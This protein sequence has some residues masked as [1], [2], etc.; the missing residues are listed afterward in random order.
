MTSISEISDR[1]RNRSLGIFNY[2]AELSRLR[3][4]TICDIDLYQDVFWFDSLPK[5]KDCHTLAWGTDDG[6]EQTDQT[7]LEIKKRPE[8][9]CP[10]P[11]AICR[12]WID[13]HTLFDSDKLPQLRERIPAPRPPASES[14]NIAAEFSHEPEYLKLSDHPD[15]RSEFESYVQ[16]RWN[17]WSETH[18]AWKEL[19]EAY[20]ALFKIHQELQR[21]GEQYE[22]I[23]GLGFLSWHTPSG[24]PVGRHVLTAQATL[25]FD[26]ANGRF[27]LRAGAEGAK[28]RLESDMLQPAD[29]PTVEQQRS[30]E[31]ALGEAAETPWDRALVFPIL[32]AWVQSLEDRGEFNDSLIR[33][34]GAKESP[35]IHFSPAII[36]RRRTGQ[37]LLAA[38]EK[39]IECIKAPGQDIPPE[40]LRLVSDAD[41]FEQWVESNGPPGTDRPSDGPESVYFPLPANEEQIRIVE[42][43]ERRQGVLVQGPP[44][45]GKSHTIANLICHLLATGKRVLV[46]AQTP[47]ALRVLQDKL[48]GE[49]TPLCVSLLGNDRS[50]LENLERSVAEISNRYARWNATKHESETN[51]LQKELTEAKSFLAILDDKARALRERETRVHDVCGDVYRGTAQRIAAKISDYAH[52][53]DWFRDRIP[54]NQEIPIG[55][56]AFQQLRKSLLDIDA[57]RLAELKQQRPVLAT[58]PTLEDFVRLVRK[59]HV[60]MEAV[61]GFAVARTRPNFEALAG[62]S[63]EALDQLACAIH[64][65]R[66]AV[67]NIERRPLKWIKDAIFGMLTDQDRPWKSLREATSNGLADLKLRANQVDQQTLVMPDKVDRDQVLADAS[68]LKRHLDT[69]KGYGWWIFVSATVKRTRYVSQQVRIDGRTCSDSA[70]LRLLIEALQ[71]RK[72]VDRLWITWKG[73]AD[74]PGGLLALQIAEL[75]E[76]LE[77]LD[78]V[79]AI[80]NALEPAKAACHVVHGLGEPPWHDCQALD[81]LLYLHNAL[82]AERTLQDVREQMSGQLEALAQVSALPNCHPV[83]SEISAAIEARDTEK[84]ARCL[85]KLGQIDKDREKVEKRS[86]WLAGLKRFAPALTDDLVHSAEDGDWERRLERIADAWNWSRA[87]SWLEEYLR[88][89]REEDLAKQIAETRDSINGL[90]AQL[91]ARRAWGHFFG[92][93]TERQRQHLNAWQQAIQ[94]LGKG[95]GRHAGRHRRQA[96]ESLSHCQGAIPAWVMPMYRVF[97]TI[98][99]EP[100][101]FDVLIVDEASQC[102]PDAL[103]LLYLAKK[104][105]VVGDDQQ[106]SPEAV[107]INQDDVDYLIRQH[108]SQ[109]EHPG[110]FGITSSFFGHG[111]IRYGNR[112]VLRE[113]FRCMPE[114]IRFSNDLCY[115]SNPLIPLRQYPPHRLKPVVTRRVAGGFREGSSSRVFNRPEA[116]AV[117][118][119]IVACCNDPQ[120]ENKTMGVI[121]LQGDAQ[122]R[123]IE[124]MLLEHLDAT[125]IEERRIIC[126]DAY[127]FQGDERN[128]IFLS[129]VAAPNTRIGTLTKD[130]DKRRFNVAASR[131]QDQ[132]WLFHSAA[133]EDLNSSCLRYELLRYCLNPLTQRITLEGLDVEALQKLARTA[134]RHKQKA[135][136]PFDSWFEVDLF[137]M[138]IARGYRVIPQYQVAGYRIDLVV[139]GT[140]ARLAVE[141]DGDE[142]HGAETYQQDVERQRALERC[143]WKF[144]RVRGSEFYRNPNAAT[145]SLWEEIEARGIEIAT[146]QFEVTDIGG[147]VPRIDWDT[148]P[149]G[150]EIID[151]AGV[152]SKQ[153]TTSHDASLPRAVPTDNTPIPEH[154]PKPVVEPIGETTL[155]ERERGIEPGAVDAGVAKQTHGV[156]MPGEPTGPVEANADGVVNDAMS[157]DQGMWFAL[158][159]WAKEKDTL[160][161]RD[162]AMLYNMARKR[163]REEPLT[164]KQAR[165]A[166]DLY[167]QLVEQGFHQARWQS[168]T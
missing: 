90:T 99:P 148:P 150:E 72:A 123:L 149:N 160:Q 7:W 44:G 2:L 91:A 60:A 31:D 152:C 16:L 30:I 19:Q 65:L 64:A 79:L 43:L 156:A 24:G 162:R 5:D 141:A 117:V 167:R 143:G 109:I 48:P 113:H 6:E 146:D 158:A 73:K 128:V 92:R 9:K 20:S 66:V 161:G 108:L 57:N 98:S 82:A 139:E 96:Q 153:L 119:A 133:L 101:M 28:L 32:K 121:S 120:Y 26:A 88:S 103:V 111:V 77:A 81:E 107:G 116:E 142:W 8:P 14:D 58:L 70:T 15:V 18:R 168:S 68:D 62:A 80:E 134:N 87:V 159:Q 84:Y 69:G 164:P 106:I 105:I 138:I 144:W 71:V 42:A 11:P 86:T 46:T 129:M 38:L 40:I 17:V 115:S 67:Q 74:N 63:V 59:E 22:L 23:V 157:I 110:S 112:I 135:P 151:S 131:A 137:L 130:S 34:N 35:L 140:S 29:R 147:Y 45:T 61:E 95:T 155:S 4:K 122:A 124:T 132:L 1:L 165:Y 12:A 125:E 39:I 145:D 10:Q 49:V 114:I 50:A 97:E 154:E 51:R 100:E 3:T 126:G 47:R 27:T 76:H 54:H 75:E 21:L 93:M 94:Q 13:E 89:G 78:L 83:T 25:E 55:P 85:E 33:Q 104:V 41:E 56:P 52:E 37:N 163:A 53:F 136:R 36:L 102:G 118:K 127:S 166:L